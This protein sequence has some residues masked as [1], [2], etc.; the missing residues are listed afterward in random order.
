M[1]KTGHSGR[2][3]GHFGVMGAETKDQRPE[4]EKRERKKLNGKFVVSYVLY[5]TYVR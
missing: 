3:I 1:G 2:E 5:E 4:K